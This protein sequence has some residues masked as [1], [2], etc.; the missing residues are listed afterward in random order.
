MLG[1]TDANVLPAAGAGTTNNDQTLQELYQLHE[2]HTVNYVHVRNNPEENSN[3]TTLY[4]GTAR[5]AS[6]PLLFGEAKDFERCDPATFV[7]NGP[8]VYYVLEV[9]G[10]SSD[11]PGCRGR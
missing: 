10:C 8:G 2:G 3:P 4:C 6:Y 5:H 11:C 1:F 7:L 9:S